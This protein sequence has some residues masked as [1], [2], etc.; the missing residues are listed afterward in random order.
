MELAGLRLA[1]TPEWVR[2][3]GTI[4]THAHVKDDPFGRRSTG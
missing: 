4:A 1:N 3:L 2:I